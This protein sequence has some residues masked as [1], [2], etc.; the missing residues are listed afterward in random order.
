MGEMR[1]LSDKGDTR[2]LWDSDNR[3]EVK[4]AEKTFNDLIKKGF[5]AFR[6]KK[7][8]SKGDKITRFDKYAERLILIPAI[9]GG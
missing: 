2:I 6:T 5:K 8:G 9:V 1:Y 3:D 7:D 4:N